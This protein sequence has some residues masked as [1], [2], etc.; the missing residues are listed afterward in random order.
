[1]GCMQPISEFSDSCYH[2]GYPA[3]GQNP[4]GFLRVR[5]TLSE[6]YLVGRVL[7]QRAD[8]A[9]YI[10][11]DMPGKSVITVREALPQGLYTRDGNAVRPIKGEEVAFDDCLERFR[12][13]CRAIG[14]MRDLPAML[15]MYDLFEENGTVYSVSDK[16]EDVTLRQYVQRCG[17]HLS[18]EEARPL[19]VP[20]ISSLASLHAGELL[21]LN[22]TPDTVMVDG[23][24]RLRLDGWEIPYAHMHGCPLPARLSDGYAAPEQY[25]DDAPG[26]VG[27][28]ADIYG[29]AAVMLFAL[30]GEDPPSAPDR[31][32]GQASLM[33]PEPIEKEWPA[34]LA[35]AL[36]EALS[37]DR[38]KR[39]DSMERFRER[40]TTEPQINALRSS[41][42]DEA[43][44]KP[45]ASRGLIA[46]V[47]ILSVAA[48]ALAAALG[49]ALFTGGGLPGETPPSET[50]AVT[51][52]EAPTTQTTEPEPTEQQFAVDDLVG[53]T[54]VALRDQTFNGAMPVQLAGKQY[55]DTVP[56]GVIIAQDPMP[57]TF[58]PAMT[59]IKVTVSAGPESQPLPD[60]TGW[61]EEAAKAYLEALGY[62]VSEVEVTVSEYEAGRIHGTTPAPGTVL[63]EGD[64]VVLQISA[65]QPTKPPEETTQPEDDF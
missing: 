1:M 5:T 4:Q 2:C 17:G 39:T 33:V 65:V 13:Q 41:L 40:L 45:K 14:R 19:F 56:K 20:L 61:E 21:H 32:T 6:R 24:S 48:A 42:P 59:P 46:A 22:L 25:R 53:Q 62:Q 30:T 35:P 34:H 8:A 11:Y 55:S 36:V 9:V 54:Y 10:G 63:R 28:K 23:E 51:T 12:K 26:Q 47:I 50:T 58:A 16:V 64:T 31:L 43:A 3:N 37:L 7:E 38:A 18:W 60:V 29:M 44:P 57:E 27:C 15:P 52:T 49:F